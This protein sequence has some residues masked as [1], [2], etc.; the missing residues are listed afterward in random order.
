MKKIAVVTMQYNEEFY[1]SRW[2]DYYARLVGVE[3][4][5]VVD[6]DSNDEV[7]EKLSRVSV[8][9]YPRSALDDQERARFVSKFVGALLELYETVIYTDCDEFVSHDPR[10]FAGFTDWLDATDFEYSTCV[11]FNVMT[12]L[13]EE[14]A[15]LLEGQ[16]LEQRRHVRFVSPM[17]K[18]L[19]VRKPIRWGGGFHHANRP[20]HFHG[21]YL[22]HLKYADLAERMRRQAMTRG[23]D[24]AQADQGHHQ[25][26]NDLD[27]MNIYQSFARLER[28]EWE[29]EAIDR[30][31]GQYLEGVTQSERGGEVG[32]MYVSP[33]NIAA[34]EALKLPESFRNLF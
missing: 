3:N 9:R 28:K 24:F 22:F 14:N 6:H 29:D 1:V 21:A 15:V 27:L 11:G 26:K 17:C 30:Y 5:Y 31:C 7:R 10:R 4:L 33:L 23:L 12:M 18:T 8:V 32:T 13:E 25:R 34:G 16:V 20:P 19:I 2:I